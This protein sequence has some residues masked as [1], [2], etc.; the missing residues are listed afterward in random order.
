MLQALEKLPLQYR[1]NSLQGRPQLQLCQCS[2]QCTTACIFAL[3]HAVAYFYIRNR[4]GEK[5]LC[6]APLTGHKVVVS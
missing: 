3:L 5:L 6:I 2:V 1:C 4:H